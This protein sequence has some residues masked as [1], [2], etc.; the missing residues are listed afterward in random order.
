MEPK[1]I[2]ILV[3][4][5][6]AAAAAATQPLLTT[7]TGKLMG[8]KEAIHGKTVNSYLG[9]PYAEP[10]TGQRRF[11]KPIPLL[12][13]PGV[14]NA[15][16]IPPL[17]M[18][19][20]RMELK[21]SEDC[22]YLNLWIPSKP[23]G[24]PEQMKAARG[25]NVPIV[26]YIP[27]FD[28]IIIPDG[29]E[30]AARNDVAFISLNYRVGALGFLFSGSP[31]APG[32]AGLYDILEALRWVKLNSRLFGGN[33][34]DI[35]LWA[36]GEGAAVAAVLMT[37]PM[38]KDL[39]QKIIFES[40]SVHTSRN[41]FKTNSEAVTSRL[42]VNAGCFNYS[43]TWES[44]RD[45]AIR[46]LK[47]VHPEVIIGS[48]NFEPD[49]FQPV[50]GDSLIPDEPFQ[51]DRQHFTNPYQLF[52]LMK[53]DESDPTLTDL[54][55]SQP[56][57][58][59]TT[60][61]CKHVLRTFLRTSLNIPLNFVDKLLLR[62]KRDIQDARELC[63]QVFTDAYFMCPVKIFADVLSG[64]RDTSSVLFAKRSSLVDEFELSGDVDEKL[65]D[66]LGRFVKTGVP[67]I[68]G[69]DVD[70]PKFS[71]DSP[72]VIYLQPGNITVGP[73]DRTELC[74]LWEPF[75]VNSRTQS[76]EDDDIDI[77]ANPEKAGETNSMVVATTSKTV[78]V[79]HAPTSRQKS[80]KQG[81]LSSNET[82]NGGG[83]TDVHH[84]GLLTALSLSLTCRWMWTRK[85]YQ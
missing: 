9:V 34:G 80:A 50:I 75:I 69:K 61:D 6:L 46:C 20:S 52:I 2:S 38:T 56:G 85:T 65:L 8:V 44:Q 66:I 4:L 57:S 13:T 40:G 41:S 11:M 84:L 25:M 54:L 28:Q 43:K 26:V 14:F 33:P 68:P 7:V 67:K 79:S 12:P 37:S 48:Q 30:F 74:Q 76:D 73:F 19:P 21:M 36:K 51:G 47:V 64:M 15:T 81:Q 27:S 71:S 58:V 53:D 45:E 29:A 39:F 59:D 49:A 22:L 5:V 78:K 3:L 1:S 16:R 10:P 55:R 17:C 82:R 63:R 31:E 32:N 24:N 60:S 42:L 18:R 70:W 83:S 35:T 62:Y 23:D 77:V 72:Q